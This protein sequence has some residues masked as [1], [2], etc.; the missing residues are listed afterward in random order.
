MDLY[1]SAF[2]K[3]EDLDDTQ[4]FMRALE[5][6][7]ELNC[8]QINLHLDKSKYLFKEENASSKLL[9][10]SNTD[11]LRFPT[12][13]IAILIEN[14]KN[15][16]IIGNRSEFQFEGEYMAIAILNSSNINLYDIDIT[17]KIPS[18]NE[19]VLDRVDFDNKIL[20][21]SIPKVF[22]YE[23]KSKDLFWYSEKDEKGDYYWVEK[24]HHTSYG[25]I[26]RYPK[27]NMAKLISNN[28]S[29]F[30]N[31]EY[32]R[33][34]EKGKIEISYKNLPEI[35]YEVGMIF[36]FNSSKNRKTSGI[37]ISESKDIKLE[38]M[39]IHFLPDFGLLAQ[40]S[41]NL[42]FINCHFKTKDDSGL[43][44]SSAADGI[45]VSGAKGIVNILSCEFDNTLD[46]PINI[47]GTYTKFNNV[48]SK[49]DIMLSYAHN[50]QAGFK[51]YHK[52]DEIIFLDKRNLKPLFK[53]R[54]FKVVESK[55]LENPKNMIVKLSEDIS[56]VFTDLVD[57][58]NV[59]CENLSYNPNVKIKDNKFTNTV[60]RCVLVSSRGKVDIENNYFY[61]PTLAAIY[62]SADAN[63][64]YE[65]SQ[66]ENL[67]IKNNHFVIDSIGR[68]EWKY[69]PAIYFL[70]IIDD[71]FKKD[72]IVHSNINISNNI[73]DIYDDYALI[74][75][76]VEKLNF[77]N[78]KIILHNKSSNY[79]K[80]NNSKDIKCADNQV[81]VQKDE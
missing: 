74:L 52:N 27:K 1:I 51:Q 19:F 47:H 2:K 31:I 25:T 17:Y 36:Q 33:E 8:G 58:S 10:L 21:F 62:I 72:T 55:I 59:V 63:E 81:I 29:P 6:I 11:T 3:I 46:D 16:N 14:K 68:V 75:N 57:T 39:N 13:K 79:M 34:L 42:S 48:I 73:F 15:I 70:P 66:I 38:N 64:W 35:D 41:E 28:Q 18:V 30:T 49:N 54:K 32:I 65:S 20:V 80:V 67:T 23:I 50:Q 44:T 77:E 69:A 4:S 24:N 71:N 22:D 5:Y 7:E 37:A 43:F 61:K 60:T 26:L 53:S 12:K 56:E 78:N 45:H 40:M 76:N 9:Y